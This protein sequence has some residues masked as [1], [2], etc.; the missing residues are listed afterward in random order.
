[1]LLRGC[2]FV[3]SG[4][5]IGFPKQGDTSLQVF[6]LYR[7]LLRANGNARLSEGMAQR[8]NQL[9]GRNILE[10]S[11]EEFPMC[12]ERMN[13]DTSKVIVRCIA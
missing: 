13:S 2:V 1:M 11:L 10:C 9:V 8:S 3:D 12:E 4:E 7:D 5:E 6:Q